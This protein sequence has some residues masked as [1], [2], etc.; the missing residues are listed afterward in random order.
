MCISSLLYRNLLPNIQQSENYA[1]LG[2]WFQN[3]STVSV[4]VGWSSHCLFDCPNS[5]GS[6]PFQTILKWQSLFFHP[7]SSTPAT[8]I[9]VFMFG[10]FPSFK[11]Q[12]N[13]HSSNFSTTVYDFLGLTLKPS[14]FLVNCWSSTKGLVHQT[15]YLCKHFLICCIFL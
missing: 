14:S 6:S 12:L 10:V 1:I 13:S 11:S 15:L 5:G 2:G 8:A 4:A 7:P 3:K 9:K